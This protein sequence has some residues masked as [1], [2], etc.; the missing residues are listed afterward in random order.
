LSTSGREVDFSLDNSSVN[1][2]FLNYRP[3]SSTCSG[4]KNPVDV[5][6]KELLNC[7]QVVCTDM[8]ELPYQSDK[9][10]TAST[11]D[12][13]STKD[14]AH[15]PTSAKDSVQAPT[16]T[17]D[18]AQ[19]PTSTKDSAPA[20]TS[21]K[22]SAPAPTNTMD[23]AHVPSS[24]KDSTQASTAPIAS[25]VASSDASKSVP[26]SS[27]NSA[28]NKPSVTP[29]SSASKQDA[30]LILYGLIGALMMMV[31]IPGLA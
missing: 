26:V 28:D 18:S 5:S 21:T 25:P 14:P 22:D 7:G 17:K 12:P 11:Q 4:V 2:K 3:D 20:P 15:V 29:H 8:N 9:A 24:T 31:C 10:P 13:T 19:A 16:S 30:Q 27:G 6:C 23:S 1:L